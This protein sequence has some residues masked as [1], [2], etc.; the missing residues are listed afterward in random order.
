MRRAI[1]LMLILTAACSDRPGG[2]TDPMSPAPASLAAAR[3]T[4]Y[5]LV[6]PIQFDA[7]A[8]VETVS[9]QGWSPCFTTT[10]PI[11]V[12][13]ERFY[14][15]KGLPVRVSRPATPMKRSVVHRMR[16]YLGNNILD[17]TSRD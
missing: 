14:S 17:T 7:W 3:P 11:T 13:R 16:S 15:S 9:L 12:R 6:I 10:P 4:T 1:G 5:K 2:A 8:C